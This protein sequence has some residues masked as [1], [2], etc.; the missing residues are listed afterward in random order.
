MHLAGS[1]LRRGAGNLLGIAVLLACA[2]ETADG[3]AY[4]EVTSFTDAG[5]YYN[6][7]QKG[8]EWG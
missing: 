4:S 6:G 5:I 8:V 2:L 1:L 7:P 3:S